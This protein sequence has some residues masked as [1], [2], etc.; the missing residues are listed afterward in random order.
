MALTATGKCV[1]PQCVAGD[2]EC[3]GAGACVSQLGHVSCRCDDVHA[4]SH[5]ACAACESGY[6]LR[7]NL[8]YDLNTD[9]Y[10]EAGAACGNHGKCFE[11]ECRCH[12]G[13]RG[14]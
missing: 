8:C 10:D 11:G 1:W 13:Y 2:L 9:C 3:N 14:L 7:A 5:E 6:E 4:L 12:D